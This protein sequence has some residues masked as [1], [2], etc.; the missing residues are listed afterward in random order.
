M[1]IYI[2]TYV[3]YIY[4]L[5]TYI[6]KFTRPFARGRRPDRL[7]AGNVK[8]SKKYIRAKRFICITAKIA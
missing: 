1:Y 5:Y 4:M 2:Y 7:E 3:L 6:H 8:Y